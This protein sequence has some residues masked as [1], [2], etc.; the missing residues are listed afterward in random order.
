MDEYGKVAEYYAKRVGAYDSQ[1]TATWKSS[2]GFDSEV[3]PEI[4]RQLK[5]VSGPIIDFGVGTGR[6][7][8]ELIQRLGCTVVG[9]D[10][11]DA[12]LA[13]AQE[14][15]D[16]GGYSGKLVL[17][18]SSMDELA[19]ASGVFWGG[20]STSA[21]HYVKDPLKTANEFRRVLRKGSVLALGDLVSHE[22][23]TTHFFDR[24]ENALSPVHQ[25][26]YSMSKRVSLFEPAGF[27][28]V[29]EKVI[30]YRKTFADLFRDKAAYFGGKE[31]ENRFLRILQEATPAERELYRVEEDAMELLYGISVFSAV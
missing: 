9:V 3:I 26:Y 29:T 22:N 8:S 30:S 2:G 13:K 31:A 10:V 28:R 5:G 21:F 24:L 27:E 15:A 23:D 6:V 20:V 1:K 17:Q 14:N 11:S 19:F 18:R 12:M 25:S 16:A 4:A 7:A